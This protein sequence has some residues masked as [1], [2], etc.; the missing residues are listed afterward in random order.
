MKT[1]LLKALD[2]RAREH[3][4]ALFWWRDDDAVAPSDQLDRLLQLSEICKVPVTLAVIPEPTGDALA[5]RLAGLSGVN[6]AAHG[7]SHRNHAPTGEKKQELGAH[8]PANV[9]LDELSE[10]F[11]HLRGL[12]PKQFVS[13]LVPPWNRVAPQVVEGLPG[14][15]FDAIST[16][17]PAKPAPLR[18]INTHVDLIDWRG[19]RGG[20]PTEALFSDIVE[21][22]NR[23][24]PEPMGLLSH[25]L[26]HDAQ[27]WSF[28][29]Q[30]FE[31]TL[32]HPGCRWASLN[33]ILSA[34]RD[35]G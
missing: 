7:W 6:V 26:V 23:P 24:E 14:I 18:V 10:G 16:F 19:T 12:Y 3:R 33:H 35:R 13:V 17:G 32:N 2:A 29:E 22:M 5:L 27:A 34:P 9:V 15:G 1:A 4:P 21:A 30:L 28:L 11:A 25:H 20:R 31:L 8:R